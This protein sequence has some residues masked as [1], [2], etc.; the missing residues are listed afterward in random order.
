MWIAPYAFSHS[1]NMQKIEDYRRAYRLTQQDQVSIFLVKRGTAG[2]RAG[3]FIYTK[4]T[5][6]GQR[7]QKDLGHICSKIKQLE[8][9]ELSPR[10]RQKAIHRLQV[11][12]KYL[13]TKLNA[14]IAASPR[15]GFV[16]A[17][18]CEE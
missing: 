18:E 2:K 12:K 8:C 11:Q 13:S 14:E 7:L 5:P 17:E 3:S 15:A 16:V 6:K 9:A 4:L 1:G 10:E